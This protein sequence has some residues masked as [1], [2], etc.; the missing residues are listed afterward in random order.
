VSKIEHVW[1]TSMPPKPDV[2]TTRR[3]GSSHVTLRYWDGQRWYE[4]AWSKSRGGTLFQWPKKSISKL[5]RWH[6]GDIYLRKISDSLLAKYV[7][8][9]STPRK[10]F[11]PDEVLKY[12]IKIGA[13]RENWKTFY[14][15]EMRRHA[16]KPATTAKEET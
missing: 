15:D 12:L 16:G 11:E 1:Q 10:L 5:P 14:Q 13:L 2:Y 6:K 7:M 4:I 3:Q 9:W 8:E